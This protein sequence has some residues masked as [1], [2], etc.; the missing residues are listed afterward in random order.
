MKR[1]TLLYPGVHGVT[2]FG[3]STFPNSTSYYFYPEAAPHYGYSGV[4][5]SSIVEANGMV[6]ADLS[7][8]K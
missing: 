2:S 8:A 7:Y 5:A 6:S 3:S 1:S 4:T